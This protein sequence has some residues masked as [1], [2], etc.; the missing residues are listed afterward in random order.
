MFSLFL[1]AMATVA[2]SDMTAT[3]AYINSASR[4]GTAALNVHETNS[5]LSWSRLMKTLALIWELVYWN[6]HLHEIDFEMFY[7]GST[8]GEGFLMSLALS[9]TSMVSSG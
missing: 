4:S 1:D 6:G 2:R 8:I 3:H 7:D 5:G 9:K